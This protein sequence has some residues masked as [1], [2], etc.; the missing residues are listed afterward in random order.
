M[1][2][3]VTDSMLAPMVTYTTKYNG[4]NINKT[5]TMYNIKRV[6]ETPWLW[7]L[8]QPSDAGSD[9]GWLRSSYLLSRR[10]ERLLLGRSQKNQKKCPPLTTAIL[11][12]PC[13]FPLNS[14]RPR[15][16]L[17]VCVLWGLV[18]FWRSSPRVL[19]NSPCRASCLADRGWAQGREGEQSC[20]VNITQARA[21]TAAAPRDPARM[22]SSL[23]SAD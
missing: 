12:L 14:L 8:P 19:N 15:S 20:R 10:R 5:T 4:N 3:M 17:C 16:L 18:I 23:G 2:F 13:Y 7:S 22:S 1:V 21:G 11:Q 6:W 9:V